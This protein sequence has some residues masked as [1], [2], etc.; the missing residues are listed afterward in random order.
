[1]IHFV[2]QT[3]SILGDKTRMQE[4]SRDPNAYIRSSAT[5]GTLGG[6]TKGTHEGIILCEGAGYD[7]VFIE[8]VGDNKNFLTFTRLG[9]FRSMLLCV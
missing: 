7:T 3:G 2:K 6:L 1:M 5:R 9:T 8:T 4:L